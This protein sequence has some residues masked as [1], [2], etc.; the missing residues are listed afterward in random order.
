MR[1]HLAATLL[2]FAAFTPIARADDPPGAIRGKAFLDGSDRP[3]VRV[4]LHFLDRDAPRLSVV[5]DAGGR[6]YGA[7]PAG[8]SVAE[9]QD[10]DEGPPCWMEAEEPGRWTSQPIAPHLPA[11]TTPGSSSPRISASR[12]RR[13]G[14]VRGGIDE[15]GGRMP[16]DGGRR[17]PRARRRRRSDGRSPGASY[18]GQGD[19]GPAQ[20]GDRPVRWAH[21]RSGAVPHAM[22]RGDA[23]TQGHGARGRVRLDRAHR[24]AARPD[25]PPGDRRRWP[26]SVR[27][28]AGW[29]RNL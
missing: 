21:R 9:G 14:G 7:V 5:T 25:R 19:D 12:S 24:G 11:R 16:A 20:D 26:G 18:A 4:T 10:G 2:L 17:G 23:A 6:F 27:S 8:V 29:T 3:A 13:P 1:M 22:V 15:L 28:R